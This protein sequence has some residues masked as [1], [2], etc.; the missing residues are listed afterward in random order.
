[1]DVDRHEM[2][3][4]NSLKSSLSSEGNATEFGLKDSNSMGE[5]MF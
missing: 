4:S 2:E 3:I 1:M 5:K